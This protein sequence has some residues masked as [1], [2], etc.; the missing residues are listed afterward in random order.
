M[1][2][3]AVLIKLLENFLRSNLWFVY[4]FLDNPLIRRWFLD[5]YLRHRPE[6]FL[7]YYSWKPVWGNPK[8]I[9]VLKTD[10]IGDY[11]LFRNY[12]AEI[13]AVYKPLGCRIILAG[14][15][16]WK[17]LASELDSEQVDEFI[18]LDRGGMNRRPSTDRQLEFLEQINRHTY[19]KLLYPNFSREWEAGDWLVKHIPSKEKFAF[20][21]NTVNQTDQQHREGNDIYSKLLEPEESAMFDFFRNGEITSV[22][23]GR[24]SRLKAPQI[25]LPGIN[26]VNT[27]YAVFFPGASFEPRRWPEERFAE[28]GNFIH[29]HLGM[30]II[31]TGGP[32]ET[33]LCQRIAAANPD[34]FENL[35][36]KTSLPQLL[37]LISQ[38]DL[39][40]SNDT[41]AIHMG[42]Q[43]GV[44]SYCLYKGNNY[45][46][47]MPYPDGLLPNLVVC[48]PKSL[49]EINEEERINRFSE[50]DGG[51]IREITVDTL[52]SLIIQLSDK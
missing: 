33:E 10:A 15:K 6:Q 30:K 37:K 21:G 4:F 45:G 13:A 7:A 35:A 50:N 23:T 43:C 12:L 18:W 22:F 17:E 39:L 28:L 38:S 14:N 19:R 42:A 32:L 36:G 29:K 8:N 9:L 48:M 20:D 47:C 40:V 51:D 3:K 5:K 44:P 31:L 41:S 52:R 46:R 2:L 11:L 24:Q 49:L 26:P 25:V 16:A 27:A 1:Q 34:I